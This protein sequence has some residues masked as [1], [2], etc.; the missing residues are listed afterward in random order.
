MASIFSSSLLVKQYWPYGILF[1][2]IYIYTSLSL[3][4]MDPRR[5]LHGVGKS[6]ILLI[7]SYV[8]VQIPCGSN[9][10]LI[11][12]ITRQWFLSLSIYILHIYTKTNTIIIVFVFIP[13]LINTEYV[14]LSIPCWEVNDFLVGGS[15]RVVSRTTSFTIIHPTTPD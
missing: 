6:K 2:E 12:R 7:H 5:Y 8:L 13:K 10:S 1:I 14:T 3:Y 4:D 11:F 15:V 9:L